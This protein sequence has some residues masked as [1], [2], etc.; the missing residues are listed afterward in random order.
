MDRQKFE[1]ALKSFYSTRN[2]NAERLTKFVAAASAAVA[3]EQVSR[4]A[5]TALIEFPVDPSA[6]LTGAVESEILL[7]GLGA[8]RWPVAPKAPEAFIPI[9]DPFPDS[10]IFAGKSIQSEPFC[11]DGVRC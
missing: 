3:C 5:T 2:A 9:P 8:N 10:G 7:Q 6:T 11:C 1:G 4:S